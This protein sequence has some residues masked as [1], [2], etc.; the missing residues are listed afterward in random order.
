MRLDVEKNAIEFCFERSTIRIYIVND[1]IHI[2]EVVTYEVTTGEYL[3]KIQIIIKNGK[4]YVASPLGVD[5]I[6]NPENTLKG[7]NEI[8]KNV[9]DSSP[10]LYEKIQ[11]IINAH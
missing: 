4:V 9:K 1:E 7:L 2:A 8:L 6:Q 10:A 5:E 3:S 11:K